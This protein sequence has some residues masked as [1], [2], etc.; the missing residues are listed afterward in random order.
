MS[1]PATAL[2]AVSIIVPTWR[3]AENIPGLVA[4]VEAVLPAIPGGAE[5]LILDD[6]SQD[7]TDQ[8]VAALDR[9]WVRLIV[10]DGVRDLSA[11]VLDGLRAARGATLVVMDADLSHPPEKIPTMIAALKGE[12]CDFVIGSRHVAGASLDEKWSNSRRLNSLGGTLL[13]RLF[14]PVGDPMSGFFALRRETFAAAAPLDPIG[15]KI[16]L[17]LLVKCD[18]RRPLEIPIHFSDRAKGESKL[19]LAQQLR[20]LRHVARLL[21]YRL[22]RLF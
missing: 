9:D 3:E 7:G 12:A 15:Y 13:A 16:M 8:A 21:R 10:R 18:I 14:T 17:E 22:S 6:N 19:T 11:A 20:Y 2:P 4:R 1:D 5:L